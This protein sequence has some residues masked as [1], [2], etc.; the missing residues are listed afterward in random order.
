MARIDRKSLA[1]LYRWIRQVKTWQL[2][3]IL[4]LIAV[5]SASLLRM[6]SLH[7]DTLRNAVETADK[8]GDTSKIQH[9][10]VDLQQ[11]VTAHMNTSLG[12]GVYLTESYDRAREQ[13]LASASSSTNPNA[14]VYQQASIEC[15]ARWR[16]G[17]ASFRN[18]YVTCVQERVR[19]LGVADDPGKAIAMPKPDDFHYNFVSP[20]WSPDLA[21]L[22]V[23]LCV[24]V[25][26]LVCVRLITAL[27]L[28]FILKHRFTTL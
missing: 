21:G 5:I 12:S 6:N 25:V 10:L 2:I 8:S 20:L 13:A 9:A 27:A 4:A 15:R 11:Y 18:D 1:H 28:R 24:L 16:G 26:V 19:A 17:V 7:M 3:V 14:A 22:S 23:L